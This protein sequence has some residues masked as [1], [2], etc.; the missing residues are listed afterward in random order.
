MAEAETHTIL[1]R[2][3][4]R[5]GLAYVATAM[6]RSRLLDAQNS[7]IAGQ[8]RFPYVCKWMRVRQVPTQVKIEKQCFRDLYE[9]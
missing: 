4:G 8:F 7:K 5:P 1:E 3:N 9:L 2:N 6:A